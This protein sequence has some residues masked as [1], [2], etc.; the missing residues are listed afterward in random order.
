MNSPV[1]RFSNDPRLFGCI[2]GDIYL[3]VYSKRRG[4]EERNFAVIL[5]F[6]PSTTYEKP[7]LQNE[8]VAVSRMA[9]RDFRETGLGLVVDQ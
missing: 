1:A 8:R 4:L 5:I 6:I 9:F 2:S 3:F 7:A